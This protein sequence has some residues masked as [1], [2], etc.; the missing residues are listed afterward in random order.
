MS[1]QNKYKIDNKF[2]KI[3]QREDDLGLVI[4][5][6]IS[7]EQQLNEFLSLLCCDFNAL[8][9]QE[10]LSYFQKVCLA[11]ALG[12]MAEHSR[13]LKALGTLRNNFAHKPDVELTVSNVSGLYETF[14]SDGKKILQ[15]VY[16]VLRK[17]AKSEVPK[18]FKK[19]PPKDKFILL[20]VTI[21]SR[22]QVAIRQKKDSF[23]SGELTFRCECGEE[24]LVELESK[25]NDRSPKTLGWYC[26]GCNKEYQIEFR[27]A[28]I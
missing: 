8:E 7:I 6:H 26:L 22:L 1:D 21:Q 24:N 19:L 25:F 20:A 2:H 5:V 17:K 18:S 13:V 12:L 4:R 10:K 3:L 16:D 11:E 23:K 14:S 27:F 28:K 9:G 15:G